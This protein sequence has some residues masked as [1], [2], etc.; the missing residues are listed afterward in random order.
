MIRKMLVIGALAGGIASLAWAADELIPNGDF[1]ML[2][3]GVPQGWTLSEAGVR[4]LQNGDQV[5]LRFERGGNASM[6]LPVEQHWEHVLIQ[7]RVRARDLLPGPQS[8][9]NGRVI[10]TIENT[11]GSTTY[12][13]SPFIDYDS[14]WTEINEL[15]SIPFDK[16]P[17]RLRLNPGLFCDG[18]MELDTV[19]ATLVDERDRAT[20]VAKIA[21]E[22]FARLPEVVPGQEMKVVWHPRPSHWRF[23]DGCSVGAGQAGTA[24]MTMANSDST[25]APVAIGTYRLADNVGAVKILAEITLADVEAGEGASAHPRIFVDFRDADGNNLGGYPALNPDLQSREKQRIYDILARP[26]GAVSVAVCPQLLNCKGTMVV[27]ELVVSAAARE[28]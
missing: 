11:D 17:V 25:K 21:R 12:L 26:G 23:S 8:W 28:E 24:M 14:D 2:E 4:V 9:Q 10:V 1:S 3:N 16:S 22:R 13:P 6:V 15:V 27:S 19:S 18:T 20:V 7:A 5:H